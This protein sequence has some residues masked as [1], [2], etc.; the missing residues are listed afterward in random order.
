MLKIRN[1]QASVGEENPKAILNGIDLDIGA[2]EVHAIM[3]SNGCGKSTL[4]NVLAGRDEYEVTGGEVDFNGEAL[5]DMDADERAAAGL[6]LAFQHPVEIPGISNSYF[7]KAALNAQR[8]ARGEEEMDAIEFLEVVRDKMQLVG[9][10]DKLLHRA[11]ND[12]FSGGEKKRNEIF[13]MAMLE[14]KL[15]ILDEI[16]S[17]LDIDAMRDVSR[18][19]NAL[20]NEERSFVIVTHRQK[21]LEQIKPDHVHVMIDGKVVRSGDFTLAE[22]IIAEGFGWLKAEQAA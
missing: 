15:A 2:G 12:G 9:L 22:K 17:G 11:V 10:P 7:L 6:F 18:A 3:G 13:Q 4:A 16:D 8:K 1:L 20:R 14:P 21:L 19:V 5:L